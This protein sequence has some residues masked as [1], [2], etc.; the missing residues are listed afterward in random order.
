MAKG[1]SHHPGSGDVELILQTENGEVTLTLKPSLNAALAIS[2]QAGGIRGAIDKAI[3]MDI[4]T[5]ISVVRLGVGQEEAKRL[6]NLDRMLYENG[7]MDTQ[8][9]VLSKCIEYLSNLARGG[10]PADEEFDGDTKD[11]S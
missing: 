6:R 10:K 1:N 5:I 11:P 7:L 9:A 4:D 3:S 2:R 8:G